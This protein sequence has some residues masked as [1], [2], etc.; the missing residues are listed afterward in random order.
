MRFCKAGPKSR[1][2]QAFTRFNRFDSTGK[3]SEDS[4]EVHGL[5]LVVG[6]VDNGKAA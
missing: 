1:L 3:T 5:A 6:L 4:E 2:K